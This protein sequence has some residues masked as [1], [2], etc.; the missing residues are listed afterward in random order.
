MKFANVRHQGNSAII[1][2]QGDEAWRVLAFAATMHDV[3]TA[4]ADHVASAYAQG[5][6]FTGDLDLLAPI[7]APGKIIAIGQNYMDHIREQN[8]TP[9]TKPLIFAKLT[10]SVIGPNDVIE[11]DP[12]V[13]EFVDWEA[14]LAVVIGKRATRISADNAL[15]YVFGYTVA[16]DV[17]A[18]DLQK[19]DGQ[20]SRAKGLDTFCPLG[21]WIV[22]KDEIADVQNLAVR[23]E[24]NGKVKQNSNTKEMIFNVAA[25][26]SYFSHA[27]TLNPGDVILTGTP[28]G[29]GFFRNPVERLT[30]GDKVTVSVEGI[31]AVTN[32]CRERK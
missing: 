12:T 28:D 19:S 8:A 26:L 25:I 18:R 22:S 7:P 3:I 14:E 27:F 23:C 10:N 21:P 31:G 15:D 11:W 6:P 20:W 9:P 1:A 13:T 24:V 29:V 2:Q 32:T 17:T 5:A 4:S 30:T 16:N